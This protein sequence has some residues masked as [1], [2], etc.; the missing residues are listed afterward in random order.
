VV[1]LALVAMLA[2]ASGCAALR[3]VESPSVHLADM[4]L[5]D[6]TLFEQ[7]YRLKL[8]VQNP[9]DFDLPIEAFS[10]EME[11]NGAPFAKGTSTQSVTVPRY[12]SALLEVEGFSTLTDVLRQLSALRP[13]E[14]AGARYRL[15]GRLSLA[16]MPQRIPFEYQAEIGLPAVSDTP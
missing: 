6:A 3:P 14:G 5:L 10:Y 9:N 4:R 1:I 2:L 16:G 15:S 11:L 13:G 7:R 8:R 12:G